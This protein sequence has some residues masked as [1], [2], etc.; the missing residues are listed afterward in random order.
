MIAAWLGI[1]VTAGGAIAGIVRFLFWVYDEIQKRK[2]HEGFS[3]PAETLRL[4]AKPE[5]SCWW[6]MGKKGDEPT[7]QIVGRM[8]A[9][10]DVLSQYDYNPQLR[11]G[12]G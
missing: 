12:L 7:M 10:A 6:S 8:F 4:A 1:A 11:R 5:G 3:V 2:K 9:T